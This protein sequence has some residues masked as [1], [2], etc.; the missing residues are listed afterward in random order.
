VK[1]ASNNAGGYT[2]SVSSAQVAGFDLLPLGMSAAVPTGS[3]NTSV[4]AP[5]SSTTALG[6][7]AQF[8]ARSTGMTPAAGEDWSVTFTAGP[9]PFV[10]SGS[11]LKA[12]VTFQATTV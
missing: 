11:I 7:S 3:L 8:G 4:T 2:L 10:A 1:V 6:A 9:I 5:F 12:L